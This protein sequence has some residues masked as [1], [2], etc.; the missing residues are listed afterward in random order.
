MVTNFGLTPGW[1]VKN[2]Q[3][4]DAVTIDFIVIGASIVGLATAY[5]LRKCCSTASIAMLEKKQ[6]PGMHA[7]GHNAPMLFSAYCL[8]MIRKDCRWP[9]LFFIFMIII[10]FWGHAADFSQKALKYK[11]RVDPRMG[12][13]VYLLKQPSYLAVALE[14]IGI[15]VS[16]S[17]KL[18]PLD[19][20]TL[21]IS[22]LTFVKQANS[23]ALQFLQQDGA[24]FN[25]RASFMG[26]DF[27][28]SVDV[29]TL[30]SRSVSVVID[31]SLASYVP[32]QLSKAI[33]ERIE[34]LA[35][36]N[37]QKQLL[38]YLDSLAKSKPQG[39]SDKE[40]INAQIML[41]G[42]KSQVLGKT[43]SSS[44]AASNFNW[45]ILLLPWFVVVVL[46]II[47]INKYR[48]EE[49]ADSSTRVR[50]IAHGMVAC[51]IS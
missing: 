33:E 35:S 25:Y 46:V 12:Q 36:D 9:I 45:Q 43:S 11:I 27:P 24:T 4:I 32:Q 10:P 2:S 8:P 22:N 34:N 16:L 29:S 37:V 49:Q 40:W 30:D 20:H 15:S 48:R 5:E 13:Y 23:P 42:Y 6:K 7:S 3:R 21:Q 44:N 1:L 41:Q 17:G 39:W 38:S 26:I 50:D 14:N 18:I 51:S 19:D 47:L 31:T 28:V